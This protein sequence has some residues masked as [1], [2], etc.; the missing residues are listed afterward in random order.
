MSIALD[1]SA[2]IDPRSLKAAGVT[3]VCRYVAPVSDRWKVITLSEFRELEAA[4]IFVTLNWEHD[5]RD[6][7]GGR[8]I[9]TSHGQMAVFQAKQLGYPL[10]RPIIGSCDFDITL[11]QWMNAGRDYA[12]A[13]A[14]AV[15]DGGYSPGVY[16]PWD[17]LSWCDRENIM[18]TFWQSMSTA[19]S[20]HRN[21]QQYPRT[22]LWQKHTAAIGTVEVDVNDII[23]PQWG[24]GVGDMAK[25]DV[26]NIVNLLAQGASLAGY[27]DKDN[28]PLN[29][30]AATYNLKA[31]SD[32]MDQVLTAL[33]NASIAS[34]DQVNQAVWAWLDQHVHLS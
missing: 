19:H 13:F 16:G 11:N 20:A 28:D 8:A 26:L 6:W 18:H 4:G 23:V 27:A 32:K 9:G 3:Q 14:K 24:I 31:L 21:A 22:Q 25:E 12:I 1:Y 17:V 30:A 34:Q 5:S 29:D 7:L 10:G 2:R 15:S 33:S